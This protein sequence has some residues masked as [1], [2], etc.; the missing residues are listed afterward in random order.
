MKR[1][2][3]LLWVLILILSFGL[4][5]PSF[6]TLIDNLDGTITQIRD[7]SVP[8]IW[9]KD[10]NYTMTSGYD[11]NGLM[12]WYQATDWIASLNDSN[13]LGYNDWRLPLNPPINGNSYDYS[14][15]FDGSTDVGYNI[16]SPISEMAYMFY[17]ELNNIGY[18][19]TSGN[20]PQTGWGLTDT[21]PFDNLMP[22]NYWSGSRG[23][24]WFFDFEHGYQNAL[25]EDYEFYAWAVREVPEPGTLMLLGSGIIGMAIIRKGWKRGCHDVDTSVNQL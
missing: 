22:S 10:A 6:A 3:S 7:G 18:C 5:V 1:T 20:C 17:V 8:L 2:S 15:S 12:D 21:V 23:T 24:A 11:S 4:P 9:L 13:H 16:N 25:D 14:F 19:D